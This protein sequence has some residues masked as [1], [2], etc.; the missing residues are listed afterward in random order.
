LNVSYGDAR[1]LSDVSLHVPQGE[2]VSLVGS[3]GAGK[4]TLL[5]TISRL[6]L[7]SSGS[8]RFLSEKI[9][10]APPHKVVER[11]IVH[12]PEGRKIFPHLKVIENLEVCSVFRPAK[13]RRKENLR[14]VFGLFPILEKR[15]NQIAG[16][17]SGGEQQMLAIGQG[18]M[19]CPKLLLID[20]P[21]LGV[22]PLIV[23][24][25]FKTI[26]E[27]NDQGVTILLVEQNVELSL[28]ICN[29]AYVLE[30]GAI[31]LEGAGRD[32]IANPH[33]KE[34]YLGL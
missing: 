10:D 9:E 20:E 14:Y 11:G 18:L 23:D 19:S 8:I 24:H 30:T 25:I 32:L 26:R 21:S 34:A 29:M 3:N 2:I 13:E 12:I 33:V 15:L 5:K 16:S 27:I 28:T 6:V 22:A 31:T 17:L 7:H 4:T 1:A